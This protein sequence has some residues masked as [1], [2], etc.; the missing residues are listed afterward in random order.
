MNVTIT[1]RTKS[2]TAPDINLIRNYL[3]SLGLEM[4]SINTYI[5]YDST[6]AWSN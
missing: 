4:L 5:G 1:T 3:D 6:D 2:D